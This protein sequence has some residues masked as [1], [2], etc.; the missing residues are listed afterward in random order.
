MDAEYLLEALYQLFSEFCEAYDATHYPVPDL[1]LYIDESVTL[2]ENWLLLR[3]QD[4][5][6]TRRT[7]AI[8]KLALQHAKKLSPEEA[9]E[10]LAREASVTLELFLQLRSS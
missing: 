6:L 1:E 10:H 9:K 3:P 2:L 8:L 4:S 7:W 5:K